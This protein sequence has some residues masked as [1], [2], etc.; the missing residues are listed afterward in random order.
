M[1]LLCIFKSVLCILVKHSIAGRIVKHSGTKEEIRI[2][3]AAITARLP[4]V[5]SVLLI[6]LGSLLLTNS[7]EKQKFSITD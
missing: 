2:F 5:V 6:I 7:A 4:L 3:S 1:C